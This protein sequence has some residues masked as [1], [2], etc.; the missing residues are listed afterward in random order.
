[1]LTKKKK[2]SGDVTAG[3]T[4]KK[5]GIP[6]II[7]NDMNILG[8]IISDGPIDLAGTLSGNVHCHTLTLREKGSITGEIFADSVF[9]YGRVK[10][11]IHARSVHLY[12]TCHIEG[13]IM[14]EALSIEDGAFIDGNCKRT[15]KAP[16]L[17]SMLEKDEGKTIDMLEN[18][19]LITA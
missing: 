14:H 16:S 12:S 15:D 6:S 5:P 7:A 3:G 4:P 19:R 11:I 1:M 13:I 8:N 10:G 18:L 17:E 9:I 2:S